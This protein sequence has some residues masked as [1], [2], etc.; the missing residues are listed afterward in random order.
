MYERGDYNSSFALRAVE[1]KRIF[2]L[3][4]H[5]FPGMINYQ[6]LNKIYHILSFL[7]QP[8]ISLFT[9]IILGVKFVVT[10]YRDV[11]TIANRTQY[12]CGIMKYDIDETQHDN[13]VTNALH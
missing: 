12:T 1:L 3:N 13:K 6:K 4:N 11:P 9:T 7:Y 2:C 10:F 5:Q 8:Q